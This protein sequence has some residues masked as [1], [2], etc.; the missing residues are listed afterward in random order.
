MEDPARALQSRLAIRT[1][2]ITTDALLLR[3]HYKLGGKSGQKLE[4]ALKTLSP[5]IY[6]TMNDPRSIELK[7]L[8][9]VLDRLP[10]GIEACNRVVLT[11]Q[12]DLQATSFELIQPLKRRRL[13]Y[14]V[15]EQEICFLITRGASEIY[16]ILTH[17]T[18]L[19][20]E[21]K[22]IYHQ[23]Y[24]GEG[25]LK[26]E[27]EELE[28]NVNQE[29]ALSGTRLDEAIWHLSLLIG[30]TYQETRATYEYLENSRKKA[31]ANSGLFRVVYCLGKLAEQDIAGQCELEVY[32]T[33]FLTQM[34]LHQMHGRRWAER[35]KDEIF[36][37]GLEGR[38]LHIISAN[39]HSVL[40]LLYGY[41]LIEKKDNQGKSLN[42][43]NFVREIRGKTA[44]ITKIA[45][46]HG[47]YEL[48]DT[49]G[50]QIDCQIVDTSKLSPAMVLP[51][52][53]IGTDLTGDNA[54]VILVMDYA[55]GF[56]AFELM[57]ELLRSE[58]ESGANRPLN[59]ESISVMGKA[60]T[61]P[62]KKGDIMLPTAHVLEGIPHNYIVDNDLQPE[63]FDGSIDIHVG[64]LVTV[65]GTSLQN[66]DVLEKFQTTSWR[67]VGLEMEGGHYQRAISAAIIRGHISAKVKTRYAYYASDNPLRSGQTL[68]SGSL[69]EEGVRPTYLITKTILEKILN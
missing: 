2:Q 50:A 68:A 62:G 14:R 43:C 12:E 48:P 58:T 57:D 6:G 32:F 42:I 4:S 25:V 59:V 30:Q 28:K 46:K 60:G 52:L 39:L 55:F 38:P 65:L 34:I 64:P 37:L 54:P 47:F 15:N 11:A 9:Y 19:Y 69:G 18:F 20:I 36:K 23:M 21:A 66:R 24:T 63:D 29:S 49:S 67:A 41:G 17:I 45:K 13:S 10:R 51:Q 35:I 1:F 56:Q 5:E 3:G 8:E 22:K 53:K 26:S 33:P 44:K 7:G 31:N 61:L 40:T 27:W 16:D